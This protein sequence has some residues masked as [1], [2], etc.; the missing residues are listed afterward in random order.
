M[1]F[2]N[3]DEYEALYPDGKTVEELP[4]P[5][6]KA[7]RQVPVALRVALATRA[8]AIIG[9]VAEPGAAVA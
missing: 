1:R 6:A 3:W 8:E 2:D 5:R 7:R 4:Y 9:A